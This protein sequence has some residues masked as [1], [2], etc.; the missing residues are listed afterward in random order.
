M[1]KI[2]PLWPTET[3][4]ITSQFILLSLFTLPRVREPKQRALCNDATL[5]CL[6]PFM[7]TKAAERLSAIHS[8]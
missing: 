1:Q 3:K 2:Q 6:R 8:I 5:K 7:G 4:E